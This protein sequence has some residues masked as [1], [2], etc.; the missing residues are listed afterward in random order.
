MWLENCVNGINCCILVTTVLH[1]ATVTST[2]TREYIPLPW[3][4]K[5]I[6]PFHGNN[7]YANAPLCDV[8]FIL[9]VLLSCKFQTLF[10]DRSMPDVRHP[11]AASCINLLSSLPSTAS[12][13]YSQLQANTNQNSCFQTAPINTSPTFM[14]KYSAHP[15]C[16]VCHI[17]Q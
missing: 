5:N 9:S 13:P 8:V 12:N 6:F 3:N 16:Y 7:G 15:Y 14:L 11:L 4:G 17:A 2:I 1:T 10:L